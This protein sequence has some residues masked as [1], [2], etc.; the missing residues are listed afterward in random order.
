M[1]E[2][3]EAVSSLS[4]SLSSE[5]SLQRGVRSSEPS[6]SSWEEEKTQPNDKLAFTL[7]VMKEFKCCVEAWE[8]G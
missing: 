6:L 2:A 5:E 1:L 4:L 3:S 8:R 7:S